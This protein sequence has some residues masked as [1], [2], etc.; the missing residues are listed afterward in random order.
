MA[1]LKQSKTYGLLNDDDFDD[2]END[3]DISIA[4]SMNYDFSS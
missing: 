2:E 4:K 3:D 1:G